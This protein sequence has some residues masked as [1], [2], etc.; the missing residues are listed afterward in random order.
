MHRMVRPV[1]LHR[2]PAVLC[3]LLGELGGQRPVELRRKIPESVSKGELVFGSR[4]RVAALRSPVDPRLS[5]GTLGKFLGDTLG[6]LGR[7]GALGVR[8]HGDLDD[9][10]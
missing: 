6:D 1:A 7:E 5:R 9:R 8:V 4:K 3:Q 10:R 2:D